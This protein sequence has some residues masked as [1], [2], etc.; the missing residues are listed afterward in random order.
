M[1]EK[2]K[3]P[4]KYLIVYSRVFERTLGILLGYLSDLNLKG[5]MIIAENP[6][7]VDAILPLRFDLPD[8]KVF[9]SHQLNISARVARCDLD[10]S[11]EFYDIGLEF[12]ELLP[13]QKIIIEKMLELYEF[14]RET[15]L[16]KE[17][18][19]IEDW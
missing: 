3:L 17:A 11:P 6:L 8:P 5:A 16:P 18:G 10:L 19:N 1:E 9:H 2:R 13:E 7:E 4:R 15:L 14:Q 12:Q